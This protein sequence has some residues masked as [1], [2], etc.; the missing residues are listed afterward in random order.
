[1]LYCHVTLSWPLTV[2]IWL[3]YAHRRNRERRNTFPR[4]L[5]SSSL[6]SWR[7][8]EC[9]AW[10]SSTPPK[11]PCRKPVAPRLYGCFIWVHFHT[12]CSQRNRL[13]DHCIALTCIVVQ[14]PMDWSFTD[15]ICCYGN[16]INTTYYLSVSKMPIILLVTSIS[17]TY[18][19]LWVKKWWRK[20][21]K[22]IEMS[23]LI[24]N[25]K[26]IVHIFMKLRFCV[27]IK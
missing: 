23:L 8:C 16:T 4:G 6:P 15:G 14:S 11:C 26:N 21:L 5:G 27:K 1:M 12:G 20:I 13:G 9:R 2:Q 19:Q 24:C 7:W 3:I 25:K 17:D 18:V 22:C 10:W